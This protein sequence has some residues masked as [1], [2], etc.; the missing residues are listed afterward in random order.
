[1]YLSERDR[2]EPRP[3][4]ATAG[5]AITEPARSAAAT[6]HQAWSLTLATAELYD[7]AVD[8]FTATTGPL[9]TA[10]YDHTATL[11]RSGKVLV[12]GG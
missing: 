11:L 6:P 9:A 3:T 4:M 1:L 2:R 10:R 5:A 7:P 8:S 12:T